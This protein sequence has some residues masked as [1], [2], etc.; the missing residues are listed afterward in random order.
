MFL[1][2]PARYEDCVGPRFYSVLSEQLIKEITHMMN[3]IKTAPFCSSYD[4]EALKKFYERYGS[5]VTRMIDL[6]AF[7]MNKNKK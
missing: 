7:K 1:K 3:E 6:S 5:M 4:A 2:I